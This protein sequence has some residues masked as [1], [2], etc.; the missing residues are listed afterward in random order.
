M[1][2]SFSA[3]IIYLPHCILMT[4]TIE[5]SKD[6]KYDQYSPPFQRW[7]GR[8]PWDEAI[9]PKKILLWQSW[10]HSWLF[11]LWAVFLWGYNTAS[12]TPCCTCK[13]CLFY[14][15]LSNIWIMNIFLCNKRKFGNTRSICQ[16]SLY[17][18]MSSF[19]CSNIQASLL[20]KID[21]QLWWFASFCWSM[22]ERL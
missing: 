3:H 20:P 11:W 14:S 21:V 19:K 15:L 12:N 17:V 22:K 16:G 2:K 8:S 7:G 5:D 4:Q 18:L 6:L 1:Y 9:W 13:I 10:A